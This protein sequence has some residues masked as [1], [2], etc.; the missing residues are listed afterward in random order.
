MSV[1]IK[2]GKIGWIL[3][4]DPQDGRSF[5]MNMH[6]IL[7]WP[8]TAA[9]GNFERRNHDGGK[10]TGEYLRDPCYET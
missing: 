9:L 8:N 10:Y 6:A 3:L 5:F 2:R 1:S 4:L 7:R